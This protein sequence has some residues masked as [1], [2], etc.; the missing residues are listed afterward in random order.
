MIK[1]ILTGFILGYYYLSQTN[2][3]KGNNMSNIKYTELNLTELVNLQCNGDQWAAGEISKRI[4]QED[5][6]QAKKRAKYIKDN[7]DH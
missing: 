2:N 6:K 7:S 1:F 4:K 5:I 3:G